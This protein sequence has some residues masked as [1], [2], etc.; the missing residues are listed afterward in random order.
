M[1]CKTAGAASGGV[2][3]T[4]HG[5]G[6]IMTKLRVNN[7]DAERGVCDLT[8]LSNG[9]RF[10]ARCEPTGR[11][12]NEKQNSERIGGEFMETQTYENPGDEVHALAEKYQDSMGLS[13]IDALKKVAREKSQLWARYSKGESTLDQETER[14]AREFARRIPVYSEEFGL[15]ESS[16]EKMV[17]ETD[18]KMKIYSKQGGQTIMNTEKIPL[19]AG[20]VLD[21][22]TRERMAKGGAKSYA[23]A[24]R[25]V[26]ADDPLLA[27]CYRADLP[28]LE[29]SAIR[30]YQDDM[31]NVSAK[32]QLGA[33]ISGAR[34]PSNAPDVP[35]M[36]KIANLTPDLV[37]NAA[38]DRLD[39]IAK[40][41]INTLGLSGQ[42]SDRYPETL[43]QARRENLALVAASE[44]G[45]MTEEALRGIFWP[46]FKD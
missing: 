32:G 3:M 26:L 38:S 44:S 19:D 11:Y 29:A 12:R 40:A 33:L 13:Y 34:L 39:E 17:R 18:P 35:L 5:E 22:R 8:D 16:A 14:G 20:S 43:R 24:M 36:L 30:A 28:Y 6:G 1:P 37:R 15:D 10:T 4:D 31:P 27:E 42:V 45:R 25:A 9:R 23:E 46:W 2:G 21:V 7:Y 41:L